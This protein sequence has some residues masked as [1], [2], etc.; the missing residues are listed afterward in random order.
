ME[1][2]FNLNR[3]KRNS[4]ADRKTPNHTQATLEIDSEGFWEIAGQAGYLTDSISEE[5]SL[6]QQVVVKNKLLLTTQ[7]RQL[8][9]AFPA[10]EPGFRYG[11]PKACGQ[12]KVFTRV[13]KRFDQYLY[14]NGMRPSSAP[15][16]RIRESK[17]TST[18]PSAIREAMAVTY[19][20]VY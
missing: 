2:C 5:N 1:N 4:K 7:E 3:Y 6:G 9:K 18:S 10:P 15:T 12:K 20:G 16:P 11:T 14:N 13:R 8:L 19:F 17:T